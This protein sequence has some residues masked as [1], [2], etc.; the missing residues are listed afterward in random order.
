MVVNPFV[1]LARDPVAA[2]SVAG[3]VL[4]LLALALA[5]SWWSLRKLGRLAVRYRRNSHTDEWW[6][7]PLGIGTLPPPEWTATLVVVLFCWAV[8]LWAVGAVV[9]LVG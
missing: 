5:A 4:A 8:T 3:A 9:Y 1:E 2:L 7:G 6:S